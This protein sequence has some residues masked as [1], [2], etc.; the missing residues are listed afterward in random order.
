MHIMPERNFLLASARIGV[1]QY[2]GRVV[3]ILGIVVLL[4]GYVF[5]MWMLAS[6]HRRTEESPSRASGVTA[7]ACI[8]DW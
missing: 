4:A 3:S 7:R 6:V 2:R 8:I 1:C 5:W